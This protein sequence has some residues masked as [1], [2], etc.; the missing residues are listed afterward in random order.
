MKRWEAA[1]N[2]IVDRLQRWKKVAI[3]IGV[4]WIDA[5]PDFETEYTIHRAA[6]DGDL[7][8]LEKALGVKP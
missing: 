6:K 4:E 3:K 2:E 1:Y 7:E 5:N 8:A